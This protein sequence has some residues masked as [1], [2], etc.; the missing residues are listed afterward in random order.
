MNG[1][2][3]QA[4]T[5]PVRDRAADF[6][7]YV[8]FPWCLSKCPYCDFVAYAAP[9]ES[10]DH[11]GYANAVLAELAA[12]EAD[13][14]EGRLAT[15]FFGGGTPSLW[16]TPE[17]A[18]VLSGIL[19]TF[20]PAIGAVEVSLECDPSSLDYD[21]A[22]ALVDAGVNRLSVG[23]QALDDERLRFLGRIHSAAEAKGA[24][25]DAVRA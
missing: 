3:S 20:R 5:P 21:R 11:A 14:P 4:A 15:V 23:V 16:Q 18:R 22:R 1:N 13:L 19:A 7:V 9:R 24:I 10:I 17:I 25:L 8:H 6:G 12:R 2:M